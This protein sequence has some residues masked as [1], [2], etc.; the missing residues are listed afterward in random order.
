MESRYKIIISNRNLYKEIEL[1]PTD[2]EVKI[3]TTAECTVRLRKE[4]FFSPVELILQKIGKEW[5]IL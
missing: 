4:L 5:Q 3:G 2:T 1:T